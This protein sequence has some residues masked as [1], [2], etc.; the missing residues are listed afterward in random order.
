MKGLMAHQHETVEYA[1]ANPYCVLALGMRTGKSVCTL[2]LWDKFKLPTLIICPAYL[3]ANWKNEIRKW[4]GDTPIITTIQSGKEIY[5]V[6]DSDIVLISY[7]LVQKAENLFKWAEMVVCDEGHYL[8][9]MEAQRTEFIHRCV[10]ENSIKRLYLLSGTP[11]KNRIKEFYSLLALCNYDPAKKKSDFLD[12]FDDSI[13]FADYFSFRKEKEIRVRGRTVKLITWDGLRN[14][15]ELKQYL[16][17]HYIKFR[18]EEVLKLQPFIFEDVL[19]S[20]KQDKKLIEAFES[21]FK[22]RKNHSVMPDYKAEAALAKV[23]FTAAYAKDLIEKVGQVVVYSDHVKPAEAIAHALG[24]TAITGQTPMKDRM[25]AQSRF[26]S[27]ESK[28]IVATIKSFSEGVSLTRSN[29]L[30]FNDYPWVP[31][32]IRQAMFRIQGVD[33]KKQCVIHRI[34]G[35]PQ[36]SHILQVL[37]RKSEIIERAT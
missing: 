22:E 11:I 32:E 3:I 25:A 36:D 21:Y 19:V 33:Q 15:K 30:V 31:G 14:E 12:R 10:Y 5:D 23:P 17:G 8:A 2:A 4:L 24:V 28:A 6:F 1:V 16:K 27:G 29:N 18:T 9:S 35:S 20:D 37:D 26:Q 34:L 7:T 13:A